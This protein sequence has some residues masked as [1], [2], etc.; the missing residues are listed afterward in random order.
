MQAAAVL[1]RVAV[2]PAVPCALPWVLGDK[3]A[4][5]TSQQAA[6]TANLGGQTVEPLPT[7]TEWI[8]HV[9][10]EKKVSGSCDKYACTCSS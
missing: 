9:D 2:W 10:S 7:S 8:A 6:G 3:V 1:D 5:W 4:A